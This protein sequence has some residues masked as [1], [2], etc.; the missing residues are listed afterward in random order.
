MTDSEEYMEE[1]ETITHN[2][3]MS[4]LR[5]HPAEDTLEQDKTLFYDELG[6][7]DTY[8]TADVLGFLGY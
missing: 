7:C 6:R 8:D 2:Q 5:C 1:N 4:F 3:A